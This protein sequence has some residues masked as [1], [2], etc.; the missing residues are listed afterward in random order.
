MRGE[1]RTAQKLLMNA[2]ME[3]SRRGM[4]GIYY[5]GPDGLETFEKGT[6][7]RAV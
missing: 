4:E 5:R 7:M 1:K 2:G 6:A 3:K